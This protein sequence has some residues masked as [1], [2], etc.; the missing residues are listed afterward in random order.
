[1]SDGLVTILDGN[2]FVVSDRRG[3]IEVLDSGTGAMRC[4]Q[5]GATFE[6]VTTAPPRV[7]VTRG[8]HILYLLPLLF[9]GLSMLCSDVL[10][11]R[12]LRTS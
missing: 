12:S 4:R 1:M 6:N 5:C 11:V 3:D 7:C 10:C 2:T 8:T 9:S